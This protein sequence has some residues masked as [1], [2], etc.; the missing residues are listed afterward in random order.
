MEEKNFT[1]VMGVK[2]FIA[3]FHCTP[4]QIETLLALVAAG[5]LPA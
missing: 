3:T 4:K 5:R 2:Q 1:G